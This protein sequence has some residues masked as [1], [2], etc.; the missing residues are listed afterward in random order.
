MTAASYR[1]GTW[2]G[3]VRSRT[4]VL[5][6]PDS[7]P[8]LAGTLWD[9]LADEPQVHDVLH[10][11]TSSSGGSLA[12]IPAF[13]IL[14]F[15]G[16]LRVFLRGG[17]DLTVE[18][19]TGSVNVNGLDVT[20]WN[21]R[22]F[23]AAVRCRL[24]IPAGDGVELSEL[25]LHEG[26]VLLQSI[27]LTLDAGTP[28]IAA[29]QAPAGAIGTGTNSTGTNGGGANS[30]GTT[31]AGT[32]I[33]GTIGGGAIAVEP[34]LSPEPAA[35]A[36]PGDAVETGEQA[37]VAAPAGA[38]AQAPAA[39]APDAKHP[40]AQTPHTGTSPTE[41]PAGAAPGAADPEAAQP[42]PAHPTSGDPTSADADPSDLEASALTILPE[43]GAS[44]ETVYGIPDED[45][46]DD[47]PGHEDSA[48]STG[49]A[50]ADAAKGDAQQDGAAADLPARADAAE[51]TPAGNDPSGGAPHNAAGGGAP[52]AP[53]GVAVESEPTSSYD[54]LWERTVMRSIEDAAVR[55][56][57]DAEEHPAEP[58]APPAAGA[59]EKDPDPVPA[60]VVAPAAAPIPA[61]RPA[62]LLI[63]SVPWRTGG[64]APAS[65]SASTPAPAAAPAPD[66]VPPH[67]NFPP[68][69]SVPGAQQG[70][71]HH[72]TASN[73]PGVNHQ[74]A[75]A[76]AI[77]GDPDGDHDGRTV[78]KSSL[79]GG[80]A[81]VP[82]AGPAADPAAGPVVLAR[83]CAQSH[84]N[85]PTSAQCAECGAALLPDAVQVARPR[86]GRMR[87]STGELV[88]LDQS[89]VIGRQPS[90]SRVQG[91]VM[92]RLVQVASPGGDISRSHVE[93]RLEGWHVMLCDLK[94]TNGTVL[95]REGQPPRRL[96]QNEMAILLD[97]DIAELGDNIS[98]RFEEI[99]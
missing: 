2:V 93:V 76:D 89:L 38:G 8:A 1:P 33:A 37:P 24:T 7:P 73:R 67:G 70:A 63:D 13:G 9:L 69:G 60:P 50:T 53:A 11:V 95:V 16:P 15:T 19:P 66:N 29:G 41:R 57:P 55:E 87:V 86:L 27:A 4:A 59:E 34:V 10:A 65:T 6:G 98:L 91:G 74:P 22:R 83:V 97:G 62:G 72:S 47:D 36:A 75:T 25:P 20:T 40:A 88:D 49:A 68:P 44:G 78:M 14:D 80:S 79:Q 32:D 94:A 96:A 77:G 90:V 84:A 54:H 56:D 17:L 45:P 5:L 99:P 26:V 48:A 12:R 46:A 28:A 31:G 23:D 21:E 52:A 51:G 43:H 35:P 42:E 61:A 92:P 82:A 18:L 85:P 71:A 81:P 64:S 58:I 30:A 39:E 3:V